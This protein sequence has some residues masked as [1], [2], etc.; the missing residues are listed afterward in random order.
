MKGLLPDCK[1]EVGDFL[2]KVDIKTKELGC[3]ECFAEKNEDMTNQQM[4]QRFMSINQ[5]C[6]TSKGRI[7]QLLKACQEL[8][9]MVK[10]EASSSDLMKEIVKLTEFQD[11]SQ[12]AIPRGQMSL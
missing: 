4:K 1:H 10:E 9:P 12:P 2:V 6:Q 5:A 7:Q 11:H 8:Q 3:S